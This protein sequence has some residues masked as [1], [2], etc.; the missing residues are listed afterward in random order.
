MSQYS[1][2]IVYVDESGDHNLEQTDPH[3]PIFVLA[4]CIVKK[5]DYTSIITPAIQ[6]LKFDTFGHDLV[7]LHEHEI[8]KS[9]P[10]FDFLLNESARIA[11]YDRLNHIMQAC[12][13]TVIASVIRKDRLNHHYQSPGNPYELALL[14]CLE[15]TYNFLSDQGQQ[16]KTLHIVVECRGEKEDKALEL[17]FHRICR[18]ANHHRKPYPFELI[19]ADKKRNSG[20][21]QLADLMARPIGLGVLRPDQPNRA[22]TII[23]EKIRK[24]NNGRIEGYG[25]KIFP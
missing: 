25:L 9:K 6:A 10:P 3:Y 19:M 14:F 23:K 21:L 12:P 11:F 13:Y 24:G 17:E 4:F 7:V 22:C 20:G 15:R 16:D 5:S 18:G 2:F 1:N 8:R